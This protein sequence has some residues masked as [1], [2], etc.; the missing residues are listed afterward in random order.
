MAE[1]ASH[2][3]VTPVHPYIGAKVNGVDLAQPLDEST[4]RAIFEAF[5]EHS[6]LIFHDQRLTDEQQQTGH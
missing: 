4:F 2:V 6:V 5:Q 1:S 3:T